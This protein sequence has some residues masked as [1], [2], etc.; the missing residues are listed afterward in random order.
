MERLARP[1]LFLLCGLALW[2]A[3]DVPRRNPAPARDRTPGGISPAGADF[4]LLSADF[5]DSR[6][7]FGVSFLDLSGGVESRHAASVDSRRP[8]GVRPEASAKGQQ[9]RAGEV[10]NPRI[11]ERT[12]S[13][14]SVPPVQASFFWTLAPSLEVRP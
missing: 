8:L 9:C 13:G 14:V 12:K 3:L 2:L 10:N 6:R 5:A 1:L 11:D 4:S 7:F